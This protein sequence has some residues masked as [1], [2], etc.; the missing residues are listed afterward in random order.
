MIQPL[1]FSEVELRSG[2]RLRYAHQGPEGAPVLLLLH[3]YTDSWFSFSRVLPLLPEGLRVIVPDQRGHGDS[4][5]P[6]SGYEMDQFATDALELMDALGVRRASV[7]GHSMGSFIAQK[8][9]MRDPVRVSHLLLAGSA[10]TARNDEVFSLMAA[11]ET[12]LD[13][14]SREFVEE[15]Q[16]STIHRAVPAG[17][18]MT[19]IA[20]SMKMPV[21]QWKAVL[22]AMLREDWSRQ[23]A[24]IRCPTLIMWGVQDRIF[25]G[26]DQDVLMQRIPLAAMNVY[27]GVGH[28]IHWESPED[29]AHDVTAFCGFEGGNH[30]SLFHQTGQWTDGGRRSAKETSLPEPRQAVQQCSSSRFPEAFRV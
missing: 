30:G 19:V 20:E 15:F 16:L 27:S 1:S 28:A 10:A 22:A 9:A 6:D 12:Q 13:P 18:L 17:F 25:R 5:R 29:F 3:G 24:T 8:M 26:S 23:L 7:V 4:D 2:V 11:V 21:R 14:I